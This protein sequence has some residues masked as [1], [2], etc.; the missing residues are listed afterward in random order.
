MPAKPPYKLEEANLEFARKHVE[1]YYASDFYPDPPDFEAI[2]AAWPDVKKLLIERNVP[3]MGDSPMT[4]AAPKSGVGYRV[5][6]QLQPLDTLTYTALAHRV[7][8]QVEQRR[9]AKEKRIVCSYRIDVDSDGRFFE[10]EHDGY[11][12]F[13]DRSESLSHAHDHV[14]ML[15]IAGFYNHIYVHRLQNSIEQCDASFRDLSQ[16]IEE[17]LLNINQRQSV[18]IPIGPAASVIFSEGVLIDVD[19]FL[20]SLRPNVTY[21]RYV[22]DFR[23]FADAPYELE[24]IHHELSSYLFKAH[25]LTL[26]GDKA[27]L[28]SSEDFRSEVLQPPEDAEQT[29]LREELSSLIRDWDNDVY[30]LDHGDDDSDDD[31]TW[32]D[33]PDEARQEAIKRLFEVL[34][35]RHVLDIGLARHVLRRSRRAR[36]RNILPLVLSHASFLLPVFRDVGLYLEAVL[37]GNVVQRHLKSFEEL[38]DD[39]KLDLP[40]ARCWLRWLFALR[41]EF[42]AS[43]KIEAYVMGAPED[44]RAQAFYARTNRRQSWVKNI[45]DNWRNLGPWDR[46]AVILAGE[47]LAKSERNVWMD[48]IA[49]SAPEPLDAIVAKFVRGK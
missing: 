38:V 47:V 25:R 5:V 33:A 2:W 49:R 28:C 4:M 21:V 13:H 45:K 35:N 31:V 24:K 16:A 27:K 14:L 6:H 23:F 44:I 7:A 11:K 32:D 36:I 30:G 10:E 37:S 40:Y 29:A 19:E 12:I 18:G 15:D 46:R 17:F 1:H 9:Q 42:S 43:K 26:S 48:T 8:P 41:P 34:V 22:D 39:R 3:D 20:T